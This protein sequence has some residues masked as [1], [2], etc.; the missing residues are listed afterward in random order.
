[1][2]D[3]WRAGADEHPG[4]WWGDWAAWIAARAGGRR[5]PPAMGSKAHPPLDDAPGTYVHEA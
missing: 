5:P 4:S 3:V 2:P 1:M